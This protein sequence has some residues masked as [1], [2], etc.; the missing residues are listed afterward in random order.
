LHVTI[1]AVIAVETKHE[2]ALTRQP[3]HEL[4]TANAISSLRYALTGVVAWAFLSEGVGWQRA[5]FSSASAFCWSSDQRS[6]TSR[7]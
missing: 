1:E 3:R 4:M 7:G 6:Y 5:C 2:F